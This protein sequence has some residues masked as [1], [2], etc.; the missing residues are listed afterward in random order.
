MPKI[1]GMPRSFDL[2]RSAPTALEPTD[3]PLAGTRSQSMQRLQIGITGIVMMILLVGLASIIQDRAA[4]TDATTVPAAAPTTEPTQAPPQ[5][6]PLV[7]AGVVPDLP[8]Q[9]TATPSATPA[10]SST[11]S[12]CA[13][14]TAGR[15]ASRTCRG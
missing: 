6:D 12:A 2:T 10:S 11:A 1:P 8:A 15:G 14:C 3:V 9:P 7:E 5:N 4:E 13:A